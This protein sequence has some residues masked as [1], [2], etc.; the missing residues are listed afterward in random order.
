VGWT[1]YIQQDRLQVSSHAILHRVADGTEPLDSLQRTVLN[2][3]WES[4]S[5]SRLLRATGDPL[6]AWT[7]SDTLFVQ[8]FD[9]RTGAARWALR[10]RPVA[11]RRW[12]DLLQSA[13]TEDGAWVLFS[14][15]QEPEGLRTL[16]AVRVDSLG[17]VLAGPVDVAPG[18]AHEGDFYD[19][20][21]TSVVSVDGGLMLSF[22]CFLGSRMEVRVQRLD[23]AGNRLWGDAGLSVAPSSDAL[24]RS[25]GLAALGDG[26]LGV[27]WALWSSSLAD[28]YLQAVTPEGDLRFAENGG[29]GVH[30]QLSCGPFAFL[31]SAQ[32]LPDGS[33]LASLLDVQPD[34]N[35]RWRLVRVTAQGAPTWLHTEASPTLVN[36]KVQPDGAG[37]LRLGRSRL[38]Q[39]Q[40]R[41]QLERRTPLG[42]LERAWSLPQDA[43][44]ILYD[45]AVAE[46][47]DDRALTTLDWRPAEPDMRMSAWQL[48]E[49]EQE[50]LASTSAPFPRGAA[51]GAQL[52]PA[53]SGDL[54]LGWE[55]RRGLSMG[56]GEQSRL[57]RLD[58]LQVGN[59]V[60]P[61]RARDFTLEDAWPNPFNPATRLA[62]SLREAGPARLEIFNLQGQR[63]GVVHDGP[64][65]AGRHSFLFNGYT[66]SGGPLA[67]GLYFYR[68][69]AQGRQE[70]RRML[71]MR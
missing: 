26:S 9:G 70:T 11:S 43:D 15:L 31:G 50:L 38:D 61:P 14:A 24:A 59:A 71:L 55:E 17:Q 41:F 47:G 6:V 68:L 33:L 19:T 13:P 51:W 5:A 44:A 48:P 39:G 42:D 67:S 34:A 56:H 58:I 12:L 40:L 66:A 63:V 57:A 18:I 16:Q 69:Q 7:V 37:N 64:L 53:P 36:A 65:A 8:A 20:G 52:T 32:A 4:G 27:V 45:W 23:A 62:F 10:Q 60:E 22:E 25:A 49:G 2:E 30:L 1:R 35:T 29:R 46:A 3:R 28:L 54:W 21:H